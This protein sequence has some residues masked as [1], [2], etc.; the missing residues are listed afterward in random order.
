MVATLEKSAEAHGQ[1]RSFGAKSI[2]DQSMLLKARQ[3]PAEFLLA[4]F[5][6]RSAIFR[7]RDLGHDSHNPVVPDEFQRPFGIDSKFTEGCTPA[8]ILKE[9]VEVDTAR[10]C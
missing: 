7:E 1:N 5:P 3:Q 6:F 8:G 10:R 4:P 2:N 9:A